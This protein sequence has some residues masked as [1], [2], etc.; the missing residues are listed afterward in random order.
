MQVPDHFNHKVKNLLEATMD[1]YQNP[2]D[3][4]CEYNQGKIIDIF[5]LVIQNNY[6]KKKSDA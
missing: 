5:I 1:G 2:Y 3:D 4:D 6:K